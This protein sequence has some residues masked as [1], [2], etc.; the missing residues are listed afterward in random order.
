MPAEKRE[1]LQRWANHV[2]GLI[3]GTA[4]DEKVVRGLRAVMSPR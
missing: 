1:A 2:E 3:S 4:A